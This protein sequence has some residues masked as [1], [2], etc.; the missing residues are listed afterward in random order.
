MLG[1]QNKQ[2]FAAEGRHS[3]RK[4]LLVQRAGDTK[5]FFSLKSQVQHDVQMGQSGADAKE[6]DMVGD[7][8]P[9]RDRC[10]R[11]WGGGVKRHSEMYVNTW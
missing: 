4:K 1:N 3:K 8:S 9:C 7:V 6:L 2:G 10:T 11:L 5:Q